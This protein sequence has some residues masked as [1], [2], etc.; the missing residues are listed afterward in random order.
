M[1]G[2]DLGFFQL[3]FLAL[4]FSVAVVQLGASGVDLGLLFV[5]GRQRLQAFFQ[6]GELWQHLL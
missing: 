4:Q 6:L 3:P 2:I 1:F 5:Q